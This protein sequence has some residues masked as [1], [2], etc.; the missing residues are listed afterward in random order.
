MPGL[1]NQ[2]TTAEAVVNHLK[3]CF[4]ST[5]LF[6]NSYGGDKDDDKP[7]QQDE[8]GQTKNKNESGD[9]SWVFGNLCG[10]ISV[11]RELGKPWPHTENKKRL[12]DCYIAKS[13]IED[14]ER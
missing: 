2:T 12:K 7:Q 8:K 5:A 13:E 11:T 4:F 3:G 1:F 9:R 6:T 10:V 14:R